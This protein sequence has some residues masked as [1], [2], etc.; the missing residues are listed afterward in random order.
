MWG[1]TVDWRAQVHFSCPQDTVSDIP[2]PYYVD[3]TSEFLP[4][5]PCF[6]TRHLTLFI[7]ISIRIRP[8]PQSEWSLL[9][10]CSNSTC[11]RSSVQLLSHVQLFETPWTAVTI[12]SDFGAQENK[13][14]FSDLGYGSTL[15][16]PS[17]D[18][19]RVGFDGRPRAWDVEREFF[20]RFPVL[21]HLSV[22]AHYLWIQKHTRHAH[23]LC[24]VTDL[25]SGTSPA[26]RHPC[27]LTGV[28][29]HVPRIAHMFSLEPSYQAL[30]EAQFLPPLYRWRKWRLMVTEGVILKP[31]WSSESPGSFWKIQISGLLFK[32]PES[33]F[34][35][36]KYL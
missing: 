35:W 24:L 13:V 28:H 21:C 8:A 6:S 19:H 17:G 2:A 23:T 9:S 15:W 10:D 26:P 25:V 30:G 33:V 22:P 36:S 14:C 4:H 18:G 7:S 3:T 32:S 16:P 20:C 29:Y 31:G 5:S 11:F 27:W 34:L 12:C 1:V